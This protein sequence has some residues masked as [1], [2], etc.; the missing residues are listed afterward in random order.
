MKK[1]SRKLSLV[2]D[3]LITMQ[4]SDLDGVRGGGI[5]DSSAACIQAGSVVVS[6][7]VKGT[8]DLV[9]KTIDRPR[10]RPPVDRTKTMG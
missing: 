2:R 6:A 10:P 1:E 8:F 4:D 3:T 7:I 9:T 5:T